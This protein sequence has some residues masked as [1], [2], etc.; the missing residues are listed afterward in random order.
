[1][2][3][4]ECLCG[5]VGYEVKDAFAA[6]FNCHCSKCRK[7][8]GSAFKPMGVVPHAAVSLTRGQDALL[9]YGDPDATHD[10]H[11]AVCGSPLFSVIDNGNTH[12]ALGTLIDTPTIAP[13]FHIYVGSKAPWYEIADGLP[14]F[15][16]LPE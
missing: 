12:V 16:A 11:C 6:A 5:A 3:R 10:V 15:E 9:I 4:G 14:Q 7:A 13:Q 8:T 2:L 1:M